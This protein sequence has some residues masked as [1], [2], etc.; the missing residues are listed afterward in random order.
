MR[1]PGP[2]A[3]LDHGLSPRAL[4][5]VSGRTDTVA[6]NLTRRLAALAHSDLQRLVDATACAVVRQAVRD[7]RAAHRAVGE[8]G[9]RRAAPAY[10][11]GTNAADVLAL[12]CAETRCPATAGTVL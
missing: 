1:D 7:V 10:L 5:A 6:E 4:I 2:A 9:A 3:A 8:P 12:L 11:S